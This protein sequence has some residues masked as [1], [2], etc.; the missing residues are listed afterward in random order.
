MSI[1]ISFFLA[2]TGNSSKFKNQTTF[3][4]SDQHK[5]THEIDD[6]VK[7][8]VITKG[9]LRGFPRPQEHAYNKQTGKYYFGTDARLSE[10]RFPTGGTHENKIT[11]KHCQ[12]YTLH[13]VTE[14]GE[15]NIR[16]LALLV[17]R[18]RDHVI[19]C[20]NKSK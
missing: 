1:Q 5:K 10:I 2:G 11:C 13:T 9:N 14:S 3:C 6:I 19:N 20:Q 7:I 12:K 4:Y 8:G 18:F 17:E 15:E 16:S